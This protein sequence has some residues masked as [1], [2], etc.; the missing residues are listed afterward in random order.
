M[1]YQTILHTISERYSEILNSN[2]VGIYVHGSIAFNCFNWDKSDIDFIVVVNEEISEKTKLSLLEVLEM[3]RKQS[4]PKGLEMSV[5]LKKHCI[6]FEYPT[7]Y[8]LHFSNFWL[9][10]YL[11]NPLLLCSNKFITDKDLAAHFTIIRQVGIVL[12]GLPIEDVFGEVPREKYIDSIKLDIG[13]SRM[14][15]LK[16]PMY[17]VLNLCRVIAYLKHNLILSKEQGGKWGLDNL[18]QQHCGIVVKAMHSYK[19]NEIMVIDEKE[20]MEIC[21]YMLDQIF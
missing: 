4:P 7:P 3:L 14:D 19:T 8:E 5:V 20:A 11:E 13:E 12:C 16:N 21:D 15:I 9:E 17:I 18:P 1:D 6:N 2:L 10:R